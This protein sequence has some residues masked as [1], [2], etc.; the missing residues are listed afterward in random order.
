MGVLGKWTPADSKLGS[1]CGEENLMKSFFF[2]RLN[3]CK[4]PP[5]E[6]IIEWEEV[7]NKVR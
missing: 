4:K 6:L 3:V 2:G 5:G 7:G 1:V